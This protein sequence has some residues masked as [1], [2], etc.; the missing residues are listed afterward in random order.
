MKF[1]Q[2][3]SAVTAAGMLLCSTGLL[4]DIPVRAAEPIVFSGISGLPFAEGDPFKGMDVSSIIALEQ[5]G[6]RFYDA[7]G[8]EQDIFR[9]L[10]DA[11]VNT[12]R[13]RIWNDPVNSQTGI[14]YGGGAN[15]TA[16]AVE[17]ASRCAAAGLKLLV[18]FHYSD[19]WADP[20]KQKAPKAWENMDV[21]Q[22]ADAVYQFTADTLHTIAETGAEIAMVQIG[23]ETTTGMCGISLADGN[24]SDAVWRDLARLWNAGASAVRSFD[25]STLVA[26]HFTNPEK[27]SNMTY[28][29][30]MLQKNQVDYDVFATS[31][32]PYWHGTLRNLTDVLSAVAQ[33]HHKQ[34]LV[35]E[36]SWAY[37]YENFDPGA[38]TI[39]S[40][41]ALGNYVSY[42]VSVEG[43][44]AFLR[45]LFQAVADVPDGMG[46]GVFYWE[47]AWLGISADYDTAMQLWEQYGAGWAYSAASEY[48]DDAKYFGGSAVDNQALFSA[49]GKPLDSLY[50]FRDIRG[51]GSHMQPPPQDGNLLRN[52]GFEADRGWSD[53]PAEWELHGTADSHFDVRAEDVKSGSYALHWYSEAPFADSTAK[54][55]VRADKSGRYRCSVTL[56][57]DESCSYTV[58]FESSGGV[59]ETVSGTGAGWN[60]WLV[61]KLYLDAAQ[62][63]ILTLTVTVSGGAG[64]Y[65]SVDDCSVIRIADIETETTV[66]TIVTETETTSPEPDIPPQKGKTGDANCDGALD[67]A[68]AV[69]TARYTAQDNTA[70]ISGQGILNADCDGNGTVNAADVSMMLQAIAKI[71]SFA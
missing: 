41:D 12:V 19:F 38:N 60:E 71:I 28:L 30:D 56:Q 36:T 11:G 15:D 44:T 16:H 67:V 8:K 9:T 3:L 43:Q 1:N 4:P 17:I 70:N 40:A 14:T 59:R 58:T 50:V 31:Y 57:C 48:D 46:I 29:A 5:S 62:G 63:D 27:A 51:D 68:D 37:T 10:A 26:L 20:A 2:L 21:N 7:N 24:W 33:K 35:A 61:P 47:P 53:C 64:A 65:G 34:V 23:N 42:P 52:P 45:D 25:R 18:D 22:K 55:V 49:D 6:V 39:S 66:T 54:T 13:I 32:Y 69:L